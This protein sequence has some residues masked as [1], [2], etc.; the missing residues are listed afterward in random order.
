[1]DG[2]SG[3]VVALWYNRHRQGHNA[4]ESWNNR[5]RRGGRRALSSCGGRSISLKIKK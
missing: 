2:E 5:M 1:M 4:E 3:V